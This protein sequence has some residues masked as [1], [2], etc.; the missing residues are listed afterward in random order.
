VAAK[1]AKGS[2]LTALAAVEG[3]GVPKTTQLVRLV[4]NVGSAAMASETSQFTALMASEALSKPSTSQ[5]VALVAYATGVPERNTQRAWTFTL[6]TH[7]F[8]VLD[9]GTEQTLVY[10]LL[11]DQWAR[12]ET[13][14]YPIWNAQLGA[15]WLDRTVCADVQS[16][17]VFFL[18]PSGSLDQGFRPVR[19]KATAI[20]P[21]SSR[22]WTSLDALSVMASMGDA[23]DGF[24][25]TAEMT[26]RYSDDQGQT[27]EDFDTITL[28]TT[29][30]NDE[31][32]FLSMGSFNMPGRII[33]VEDLGGP[34]RIDSAQVVLR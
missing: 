1:S 5:L 7:T 11:T 28:S 34:V 19:R 31:L 22:N 29:D 14:G 30:T 20:I 6:D 33:L 15:E 17:A 24:A 2:Q 21:S 12:W 25:G 16:P 9:L 10:D 27:F 18:N 3:V 32:L 23:Q 8:Y 4:A 13:E 26:I